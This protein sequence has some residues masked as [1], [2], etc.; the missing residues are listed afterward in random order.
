MAK[1]IEKFNLKNCN[2]SYLSATFFYMNVLI[3]QATIVSPSSPLNGQK[4]DI[5]IKD[6]TISS[7]SD[8]IDE[9]AEKVIAADGLC[10]SIG[11]MDI[12]ADF[13]DP[14]Y[15]YRENIESGAKAAAAGG[16]TSIM[17]VPNS[18]PV[19]DN[20][21]Q[22]AYVV[23]KAKQQAVNI[24]PVGAISKNA[25]GKELAEMYDMRQSGALAFSD[26]IKTIQNAG[27]LL[28]ALQYVK[29]FN[30]TII[31]LPDDTSIGANGLMNEGIIS[32]Q[33]GLPGKPILAEELMVARDLKLA[34]YTDS[35]IH[36]TGITSPK[37]LEYIKRSKESGIQVSCSVTPYQFCFCDEDLQQYDTN[38]KLNPPVR[39][40]TEMQ[41][42]KTAL[43]DGTI[44]CIASHHLPQH[45]DAKAC[46][47]EYAKPG[48]TALETM[49]AA[50]RTAG[51]PPVD[52]VQMQAINTRK[53]F[54]LA[55]PEIKEGETAELTLFIPDAGFVFT[56]SMIHS[57]SKNTPFI[58]KQ[59]TGKVTGI[60]NGPHLQLN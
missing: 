8:A 11:W 18:K 49:F 4:K 58:D 59:L 45:Q 2:L 28:K 55:V 15:E 37:S 38:L 56:E 10:V 54:G 51:L 27:L 32:T 53:I 60:I 40:R 23:Q 3:K 35:K 24:H 1:V 34:R 17:L 41:A 36:F 30:G 43:L 29:N 16:F 48:M 31:Q 21:S 12:F 39:T 20:K 25:E 13:A 52:F 14:G 46:E 19:I 50:A 44:D 9:N 22:A 47:F 33:M 7:I 5:L 6:G 42:I 57:R 26:G